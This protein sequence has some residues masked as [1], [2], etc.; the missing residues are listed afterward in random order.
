[1]L[2]VH[3][4]PPPIAFKKVD[5]LAGRPGIFNFRC[6][7]PVGDGTSV[8]NDGS[9]SMNAAE[10]L[11]IKSEALICESLPDWTRSL[12]SIGIFVIIASG[13]APIVTDC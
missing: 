2:G 3:C 5:P 1:M 13:I 10:K 11:F 12:K 6:V 9:I 7:C 8:A 4:S